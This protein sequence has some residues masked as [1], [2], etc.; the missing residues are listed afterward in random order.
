MKHRNERGFTLIEAIVTILI[1]SV[2]VPPT[3]VLI[4]DS[5]TRRAAPILASRA[6]WLAGEKLEDIIADRHSTTRGW[7]YIMNASYP[8]ENPVNGFANF[9]RAVTITE[10]GPDLV[11][12]GAGYKR[13]T[14]TV[15][16]MDPRSGQ[17][18]LSLSTILT[19][20]T[21]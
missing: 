16:W 18:T 21:P 3:L 19:D 13:A 1:V 4:R 10:A 2:M 11:T 15:T 7:D 14:V 6:R 5:Q 8:S 9:S 17:A 20:F 12:P